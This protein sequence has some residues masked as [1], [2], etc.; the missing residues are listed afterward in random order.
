VITIIDLKAV[1]A[2]LTIL[3]GRTPETSTAERKGTA[4]RLAPYRDGVIF[5]SK[6]SGKGAWERH[7][8]GDELVQIV[9]GTA[10]LHI[11]TEDGPQSFALSAGMLA[12]VPQG[13]WHRFHCAGGVTLITATPG[14]S[15]HVRLDIDD[16]R[17][18]EPQRG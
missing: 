15:E 8:E 2:K 3:H 16:P 6:F 5:A 17:T 4:A 7:P 11:I 12:I 13:A 9:D 14:T 18:V 1:L 10:T